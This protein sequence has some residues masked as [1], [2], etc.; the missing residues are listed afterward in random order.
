MRK[1]ALAAVAAVVVLPSASF[2]QSRETIVHRLIEESRAHYRGAC[3]C[4][5]DVARDGSQ[6][7]A[8][9]AYDKGG[10]LYC[11]ERDVPESAIRAYRRGR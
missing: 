1:L 4:P 2:A 3:P 11:F 5:Y 7:G 8:R 6:C 10:G 9:S